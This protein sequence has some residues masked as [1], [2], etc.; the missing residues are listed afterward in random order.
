MIPKKKKAKTKKKVLSKSIAFYLEFSKRLANGETLNSIARTAHE[1]D[2]LNKIGLDHKSIATR[3]NCL[4]PQKV[5]S[6]A[7]ALDSPSPIEEFLKTP[8]PGT[9]QPQSPK[10]NSPKSPD[11]D[12]SLDLHL[13]DKGDVSSSDSEAE[14]E[15]T[16]F[17]LAGKRKNKKSPRRPSDSSSGSGDESES[18]SN[19][20]CKTSKKL[21]QMEKISTSPVPLMEVKTIPP[22]NK[23]VTPPPKNQNKKQKLAP[24]FLE[25]KNDHP[26][27]LIYREISQYIAH[28]RQTPAGNTLLYPANDEHRRYLIGLKNP[29]YT[30]RETRGSTIHKAT[31]STKRDQVPNTFAVARNVPLNLSNDM[32]KDA[33]DMECTRLISASTN[34][35]TFSVKI[36]FPSLKDKQ[37]ALTNGIRIGF[38]KHKVV[39]FITNRPLQCY[40]CQAFNHTAVQCPND[41]RCKRCTGRH[42]HTD[43]PEK[44]PDAIVK[45]A[46]C[47]QEHPSTYPGCQ[48]YQEAR[49]Q[50]TTKQVTWAQKVAAPPPQIDILRLAYSISYGVFKSLKDVAPVTVKQMDVVS[51][52]CQGIS[53]VYKSPINPQHVVSLNIDK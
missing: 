20:K 50:Q 16:G 22:P 51:H 17:K 33:L 47:G 24:L 15:T 45:C 3:L 39:D 41:T 44:G 11:A 30:I 1:A 23:S 5:N 29:N 2:S 19:A 31:E 6:P 37:S 28:S 12:L 53:R 49:I 13:S 48:Y 42:K 32:L 7:T 35:K 26:L 25:V 27:T 21:K 46:N 9:S 10:S 18:N 38:R 43:C 34:T 8:Q 36:K 40:K 52:V 14:M 4:G